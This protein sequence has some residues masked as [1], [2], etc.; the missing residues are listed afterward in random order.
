M[1][2]DACSI[3]MVSCRRLLLAAIHPAANA[4]ALMQSAPPGD[5]CGC[6]CHARVNHMAAV[7]AATRNTH[8]VLSI[9]EDVCYGCGLVLGLQQQA[10]GIQ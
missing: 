7:G 8:P 3:V 5:W 9:P 4:P 10:C 1:I 6:S 2:N